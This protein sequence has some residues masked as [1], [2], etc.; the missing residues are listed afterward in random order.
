MPAVPEASDAVLSTSVGRGATVVVLPTGGAATGEPSTAATGVVALQLWVMG[1]TAAEDRQEHGCAHLLEHMVFKPT[2]EGIDLAAAIEGL[3]GDINAFT[4]HD[5]TVVHATVPA[6]H[7]G[8]ALDAL[9]AAV[10]RP[11]IDAESLATEAAVVVEEILQYRDD[12]GAQGIQ[13]LYAALYGRHPYAR[14]VLG[15]AADVR[16]HDVARLRRFHR[17]VYAARRT[18]VVVVGPVDPEGILRQ[19]RP[20]LEALPRGRSLGQGPAVVEPL[21]RARVRVRE[22][23]VGE[24]HVQLAWRGPPLPA[25]DACAMEVAGIVLGHGEASRLMRRVRRRGRLVSDVHASFVPARG[26]SAVVIAAHAECRDVRAAVEGL[27]AEV[28]ALGRIPMGEDELARAKAVLCSDL[29]YRRETAQGHAHALGQNLSLSGSLDLDRRY[30]ATLEGISAVDVR[31]ACARWLARSA[32]AVSVIV[33]EGSDVPAL[34]K[35]LRAGLRRSA[36]RS[37]SGAGPR[38]RPDRHGVLAGRLPGGLR[39]LVNVDR[40]VPMAAGW[41][42]WPG[43]LRRESA[44]TQGATAMMATLLTRG[45]EA[46]DGDALAAEIEGQA[47]VLDGFSSRNSAG[48]H[49]ECM[50]SSL[51]GVLRRALQCARAPSF[52]AGELDEERRVV[53]QE[54]RAEQ[55]EPPKLAFRHAWARLYRGHPFRWRRH[56]TEV[57]LARLGSVGLRRAWARGYPLGRAVL[58]ISGDVDVEGLMGV[59]DEQLDAG[60]PEPGPPLVGSPPRYPERPVE[61]RIRRDREQSHLVLAVPGLP[62]TDRRTVTLDVLLAVLGGQAGRLFMA[63]REAEGLVYHVSASS[64]EGVD[65]GDVALY[66]AASPE[67]M[68]RARRVLE[69]ELRRIQDE[70]VG[71]EELERAKALLVGQHVMGLERHGRLA[72]LLAFNEAYGL[73]RHEH[74]RYRARVEAVG[75]RTLRSLARELFDPSRRVAALVGP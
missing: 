27:M 2:A 41:L 40:R 54:I 17:R 21:P 3:G 70:L 44:R 61:V 47:A 23:D 9:L 68:P 74:L 69:R 50:A 59:L 14:P 62:F 15:T 4:S 58:A 34:R 48:L 46:I 35:D 65:A 6:G 43:G 1:G 20:W 55:D 42:L 11:E 31:R 22:A 45:C 37:R 25:V 10:L 66:A 7:E 49:L 72:S 52:D 32:A 33:P 64:T 53:L 8:A 19:A 38:L 26:S 60:L 29:V 12:P 13:D 24:A 18:H 16:G 36:K 75:P 5:E 28:E 39:V 63:L 57:T 73:G 51:P 56:G 30:Y 71:A 67:R